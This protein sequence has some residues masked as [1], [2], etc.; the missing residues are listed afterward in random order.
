[1]HRI[2]VE[3]LKRRFEEGILRGCNLD[4]QGHFL[5]YIVNF[6]HKKIAFCHHSLCNKESYQV[7]SELL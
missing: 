7:N 2:F 5:L 1:M 6:V 3:D 4:F